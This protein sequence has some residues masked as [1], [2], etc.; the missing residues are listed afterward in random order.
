MIKALERAIKAKANYNY[1]TGEG[2]NELLLA[3]LEYQSKSREVDEA[4]KKVD[5]IFGGR[6]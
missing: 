1:E 3:L 5:K 4:L 6:N 2:A